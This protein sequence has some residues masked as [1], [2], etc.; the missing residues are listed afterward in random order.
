MLA[1]YGVVAAYVYGLLLNLSGLAVRARRRGARPHRVL[2]FVPGD[3]L[4]ENLHRVRA[5]TR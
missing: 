3:P 2:S 1:A 4:S 5:S